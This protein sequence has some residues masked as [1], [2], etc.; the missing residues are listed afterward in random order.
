[1]TEIRAG[2]G[3]TRDTKGRT[4]LGRMAAGVSLLERGRIPQAIAAAKAVLNSD[5][6]HLGGL[7]LLARAHWRGGH[8]A[9]TL[10]TLRHLVRLNPYEP[11]YHFMAGSAHQALGHYGDA[12]RSYSRCLDGENEP[13]GRAAAAA[14]REL[15]TWQESLIADLLRTDRPFQADYANS[16]FE[17]CRKRGF[18]FAAV[19]DPKTAVPGEA[20]RLT[21]WERPS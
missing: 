1:M 15:E 9:E 13:L 4:P 14:I 6:N 2:D 16:P 7:E 19:H 18:E 10:D 17:A 11:G 3:N 12:V 8:F 21:V 20:V 5:P